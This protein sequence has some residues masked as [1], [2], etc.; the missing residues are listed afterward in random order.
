MLNA[1]RAGVVK[2]VKAAESEEM[3]R[4]L[5]GEGS[6][7]AIRLGLD[8]GAAAG[9]I[10]TALQN[11]IGR[12]QR[13]AENPLSSREAAEASRVLIRTCEGMLVDVT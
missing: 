9:E 8:P 1:L 4:L 12:W 3:E 6:T 13:R 11:A 5:G 10:R 7:P 2:G